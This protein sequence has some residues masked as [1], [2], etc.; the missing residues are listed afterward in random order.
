MN[1]ASNPVIKFNLN[2]ADGKGLTE[3]PAIPA[4]ELTAGNPVQRGIEYFNAP[5][6]GLSA[7]VWDCTAF[8]TKM[9]PY[10]VNEFMIVLDGGVTMIEA[11]GKET[12]ISAGDAFIIP[13]GTVCQWRQTGYMK[14]YYVIFDDASGADP[15]KASAQ[16]IMKVDISLPHEPSPSPAP[17]LLLSPSPTQ[18]G[19]NWIEDATGQWTMGVWDSTPYRRKAIPFPRHELMH[20]LEGSVTLATPEGWRE[21]YKAGDTFF[22]PMG[23]NVEWHNT[24]YVKKYYCIM[25]PKA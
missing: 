10:P 2:G 21:T 11:D 1:V 14:K 19:R 12:K 25:I 22:V 3:W 16:K 20:L 7:G 15:A 24:E 18:T 13:K 23:A 6:I 4:A 9:G 5:K 17:E 8:T